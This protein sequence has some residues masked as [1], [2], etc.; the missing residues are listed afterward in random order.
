MN[1]DTDTVPDPA[2]KFDANLD[3]YFM[4]MQMR[5]Q[6]LAVPDPDADPFSPTLSLQ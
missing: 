3:I 5:I 1:V 2:Y 4:S 6:F